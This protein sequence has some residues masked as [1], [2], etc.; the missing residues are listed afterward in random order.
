MMPE[1]AF[2]EEFAVTHRIDYTFHSVVEPTFFHEFNVYNNYAIVVFKPF[3]DKRVDY[4]GRLE[5]SD[6]E[7]FLSEATQ[8]LVDEIGPNNYQ[9][10]IDRNRPIVWMF[11]NYENPNQISEAKALLSVVAKNFLGKLSFVYLNGNQYANMA[12]KL[13]LSGNRLPS[14]A[15]E[16]TQSQHFALDEDLHVSVETVQ[17][18]CQDYVNGALVPTMRSQ[19]VPAE[20][21]ENGVR[22]VVGETFKQIVE[23]PTRDVLIEFYAP[24]CGHCKN[25]APIYEAVAKTVKGVPSLVVAKIDG[26]QNDAPA[27]FSVKGFPTVYLSPAGGDP[28]EY[29]GNRTVK[30]F[31]D[32]IRAHARHELPPVGSEDDGSTDDD[33]DEPDDIVSRAE[34]D[35]LHAAVA[36]LTEMNQM[37]ETRLGVQSQRIDTLAKE[38]EELRRQL[39]ELQ[40]QRVQPEE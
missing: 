31:I 24:W 19:P 28:V 16:D 30:S 37:Q 14:L 11:L 33:D 34:V 35:T 36:K 8:K 22:V 26:T 40:N 2:F 4:E 5:V 20:P 39:A 29:N 10:Y 18:F 9:A 7:A 3:D 15:I 23:D 32:F 6:F 27:Y 25:L 12:Q 1:Y 17:K 13:G 38:L 21:E